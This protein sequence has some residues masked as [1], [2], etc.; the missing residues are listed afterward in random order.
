MLRTLYREG[1]E[2]LH[3]R[4]QGSLHL[5]SNTYQLGLIVQSDYLHLSR[6]LIA[7]VGTYSNL[8]KDISRVTMATDFVKDLVLFPYHLTIDRFPLTRSEVK[9]LIDR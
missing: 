3:Q 9:N 7:M 5:M 4:M 1:R 8:Y 2:G 6:S